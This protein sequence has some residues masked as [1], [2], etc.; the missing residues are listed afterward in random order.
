MDGWTFLNN[1]FLSLGLSLSCNDIAIDLSTKQS[2]KYSEVFWCPTRNNWMLSSYHVCILLHYSVPIFQ[3]RDT[4]KNFQSCLSSEKC[5]SVVYLKH[6][7]TLY[8]T[9]QRHLL[10]TFCCSFVRLFF[11]RVHGTLHSALSVCPSI[12]LSVGQLV[13]PSHFYFFSSILFPEVSLSH[14]RVSLAHNLQVM[15]LFAPLPLLNHLVSLVHHCPPT[16]NLGVLCFF[17]R[18]QSF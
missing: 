6:I 5:C 16:R 4:Q 18:G 15:A 14:L 12:G 8:L 1:F 13:R 7:F 17:D 11:S 9:F 10:S 3:D 2:M